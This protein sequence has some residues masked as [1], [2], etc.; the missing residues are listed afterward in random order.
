M[1]QLVAVLCMTLSFH[2]SQGQGDSI[3]GEYWVQGER[4]MAAGFKLDSNGQF[5]FFFT[6]GALDRQAK[7]SWWQEGGQLYLNSASKG[8]QNFQLTDSKQGKSE[9]VLVY[10][11]GPSPEMMHY[12]TAIGLHKGKQVSGTADKQGL[13]VL[14]LPRVD[15]LLLGFDWCPEKTFRYAVSSSAHN[16]F[17]FRVLPTLTDVVF[18]NQVFTVTQEGIN[19]TLPFSGEHKFS[20]RRKTSAE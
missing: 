4:E 11:T 14:G 7:G 20:F 3:V 6:Y 1:K 9:Q 12:F 18:D 10:L 5:Q 8:V 16:Q 19:G 13:I 2:A 17:S 15:S